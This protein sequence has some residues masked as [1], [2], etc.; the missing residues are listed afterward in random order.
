MKGPNMPRQRGGFR[1]THV[2]TADEGLL[3]YTSQLTIF[4]LKVGSKEKADRK[5]KAKDTCVHLQRSTAEDV[6]AR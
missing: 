4:S 6:H 3:I 2:E 5:E 1:V